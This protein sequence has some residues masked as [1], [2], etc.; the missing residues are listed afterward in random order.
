MH[1]CV[2]LVYVLNLPM[3]CT[4]VD[5][6]TSKDVRNIFLP[7]N[8]LSGLLQQEHESGKLKLSLKARVYIHQ[9]YC[10]EDVFLAQYYT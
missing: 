5:I 6:A 10:L 4:F 2:D 8:Q 7:Y 3:F 1:T 9:L